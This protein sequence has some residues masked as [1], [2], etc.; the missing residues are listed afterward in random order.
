MLYGNS[1]T[2][3]QA[4][5]VV[6]RVT[7]EDCGGEDG[8]L[9]KKLFYVGNLIEKEKIDAFNALS[10][11]EMLSA[12]RVERYTMTLD[13]LFEV[14]DIQYEGDDPEEI[15]NEIKQTFRDMYGDTVTR[16]Q[17]R[18]IADRIENLD[19]AGEVDEKD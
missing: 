16:E 11:E 1:V 19:E 2:A 12:E 4:V 7:G 9:M 13:H 18:I 14:M 6:N 5:S 3:K 15:R 17:A 8:E 10:E